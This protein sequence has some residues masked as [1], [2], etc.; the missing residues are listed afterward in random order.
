MR[1]A[2][3]RVSARLQDAT[4]KSFANESLAHGARQPA[5]I[6]NLRMRELERLFS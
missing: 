1:G 5:R 6:P 3:T 2:F 4:G